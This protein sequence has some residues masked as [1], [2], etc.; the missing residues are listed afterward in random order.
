MIK[1]ITTELF[2]KNSTTPLVSSF[3][4]YPQSMSLLNEGKVI[5]VKRHI[6]G[7]KPWPSP[8]SGTA[9]SCKYEL[10]L[11]QGDHLGWDR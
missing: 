10:S 2:Y 1:N 6:S 5:T 7:S 3:N 9:G 11:A 8:R 4:L